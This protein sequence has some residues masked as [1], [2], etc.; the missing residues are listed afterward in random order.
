M[1][2]FKEK[3]ETPPKRRDFLKKALIDCQ[4][5]IQD[6]YTGLGTTNEPDLIDRYIYELNAANMRYRVL[7]REIRETDT[8]TPDALESLAPTSASP[9]VPKVL[10]T[11]AASDVPEA[12]TPP[13]ASPC[14]PEVLPALAASGVSEALTPT[15]AAGV[16][17]SISSTNR[18]TDT[19]LLNRSFE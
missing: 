13:L 19:S 15:L 4:Q 18:E 1:V 10:P 17:E 3:K 5:S 7:L 2:L 6:A 16:S 12:L 9:C 8:E 14:V 11:L